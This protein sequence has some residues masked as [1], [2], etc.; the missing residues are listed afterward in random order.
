MKLL[1]PISLALLLIACAPPKPGTADHQRLLWE[2]AHANFLA[3]KAQERKNAPPAPAPI[4][5]TG[6]QRSLWPFHSAEP[7][8]PVVAR[9][10]PTPRAKPFWKTPPKPQPN[11]TLYYWDTPRRDAATDARYSAAERRYA[12]ELAKSP[13]NLTSEERLW[14]RTH[15]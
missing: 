3:L 15:Y 2:Q 6:E 11:D 5:R 4:A 10:V 8:P 9:V 13:E 1:F 7:R 14:A 12:R